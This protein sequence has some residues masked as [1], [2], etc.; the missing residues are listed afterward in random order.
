MTNCCFMHIRFEEY[1][2]TYILWWENLFEYTVNKFEIITLAPQYL[3]RIHYFFYCFINSK[4]IAIKNKAFLFSSCRM[5]S[6]TQSSSYLLW[7][8]T[9]QILLMIFHIQYPYCLRCRLFARHT[10]HHHY[11]IYIIIGDLSTSESIVY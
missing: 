5:Y 8:S 4:I 9:A 10:I 7:N 3:I 1:I 11:F 2:V 6:Y